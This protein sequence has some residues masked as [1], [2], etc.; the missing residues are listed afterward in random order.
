MVIPCN[1]FLQA[2]GVTESVVQ[3]LAELIQLLLMSRGKAQEH[4]PSQCNNSGWLMVG[5]HQRSNCHQGT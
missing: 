4:R 5:A 3:V 2:R 1:T